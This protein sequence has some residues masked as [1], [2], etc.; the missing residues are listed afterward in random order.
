LLLHPG[1]KFKRFLVDDYDIIFETRSLLVD[2]QQRVTFHLLWVRGHYS[3]NKRE[4]EHDL[5]EE[6][7]CLTSFSLPKFFV[8]DVSPPSSL[9]DLSCGYTLTS[10]WQATLLELAH[11]D[12]LCKTICKNANWSEDTFN[13]VDWPALQ[14]CMFKLPR[15][16]QLSYCMLL[17]GLLNMNAQNRKFYNKVDLCPCCMAGPESFLHVVT[18]TSPMVAK[19]HSEQQHLLWSKLDTMQTP[20]NTLLMIKNGIIAAGMV[21]VNRVTSLSA[22]STSLASDDGSSAH[23]ST[24]QE[25]SHQQTPDIGWVNFF[26]GQ[27]LLQWKEAVYQ[28]ALMLQ[29]WVDKERWAA[30]L[31]TTILQYS[32]SL[33]LFCCQVVHGQSKVEADERY[34][35]HLRSQVSAAYAA[36]LKD[37]FVVMTHIRYIFHIPLSQ[38]LQQDVDALR[39]FLS[40]YHLA[41][42]EQTAYLQKQAEAALT[43]FF[44]TVFAYNSPSGWFCKLTL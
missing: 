1:R 21:E 25:A 8:N 29:C 28:D 33:W 36:F 41:I 14:A 22:S 26:H 34:L 32:Q 35:A 27:I 16:H 6:A 7:H 31:V 9:V 42:Q 23:I 30:Q 11:A 13:K 12:S 37:P 2:L 43:F 40:T 15:I 38:R 10:R 5:N 44:S 39:C 17:H 19:Y 20:P 18:C 24:A 4:L 3:G